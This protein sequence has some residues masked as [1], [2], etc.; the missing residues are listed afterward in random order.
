MVGVFR[1]G[2]LIVGLAMLSAPACAS[3]Q[4]ARPRSI[5][6]LDQSD[7]RG[8]F[9]YQ[10]FAGLRDAV[11]ADVRS[12]TTIYAENLDL[13][14]FGG[15]AYEAS[16]RRH[17]GEKYQDTRI[18]V[19][20]AVGSAALELALR[21]RSEL[22]S[23]TPI[24]FAMVEEMDF[25]RLKPPPDVTGGVVR[26]RLADSIRVARAIVPD[27][28]TVAV[29]GD[30]WKRQVVFRSWKDEIA[31]ATSGL[32]VIEIIG[33]TM[34]E[35]RRR[36]AELPPRS[37]ILYSAV[38]SDGEGNFY[39]PATALSRIA[40]KAN[41]PIVVAAE[42][43]LRSGG[44]GGYVLVP[45]EIG[46]AAARLA[47][48]ILD[49]EPPSNIAP[50][51][52]GVKP[53]FNW[54]QMQRWNVSECSLP[55]GSEIRFR[56][57]MFF[58]KYRW[59][60]TAIVAAILL[61]TTLITF[62]FQERQARRRAEIESRS[63]LTELAHV[64]RLAAAGE[65]SASIA[66]EI[67]QPLGSILTNTEVAELILGSQTPDLKEV[68]EILADIKRDDLRASDVIRRMRGFLKRT[69]FDAQDIDLNQTMR[70]VFEFLSLQAS[71]HNVA[72]YLQTS[73]GVLRVRGDPVQLQQVVVNLVVNGMDAMSKMPNGRT[74]IGRTELSGGALA[75]I[76]I[77][78]SGPGVP[79][80]RLEQIFDRFFTTK[81]HGMGIGLSIA[82][83]IVLAHQGKIWAENRS[84]G[85]AVFHLSLPLA[86]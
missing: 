10:T 56:E 71:E 28:D 85:G 68:K 16:L 48:R 67:N 50:E 5:L 73:P 58:E 27:L 64:S 7:L 42:T 8:P 41:R 49:G 21:W 9:Y 13:N 1:I 78:D 70:E 79:H 39:P 62:M 66:H 2:G 40:E 35:I 51:E 80:D 59:W 20:V 77:S 54:Q 38:Y 31:G 65:L 4:E 53:I 44:I 76:S 11:S 23:G 61:Q 17:L 60:A 33:Q 52:G 47:L 86:A 69:S 46:A 45:G 72:L 81:E 12:H 29:V 14:R 6:V 75:V 84:N 34:E 83:R 36:V 82:R 3:G 15:E 26:V 25:A 24:V 55:A 30:P 32:T 63:R 22:W 74:V 57:P 19:I 43:F 18:G 37:A